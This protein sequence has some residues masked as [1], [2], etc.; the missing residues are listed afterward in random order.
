MTA[1]TQAGTAAT[2]ESRR[3]SLRSLLLDWRTTFGF[4]ALETIITGVYVVVVAIAI[5]FHEPWSDE[6]Q[7]WVI[8]RDNSVWQILRYRLHYEGS[9]A[10]WHLLVHCFQLLGGRYSLFDWFGACFAIGGVVVWLR[11]SPFP[12]PVRVLLPFTFFLQYQYAVIAR[13][14]TLFPL[15]AFT[16][17]VL[18]RSRRN[19]LWFAL[20][21]GLIANLTLQ[22]TVFSFFIVAL[23][24][25]DR[26][27]RTDAPDTAPVPRLLPAAA[28]Y[29]VLLAVAGLVALPAPDQGY[30]SGSQVAAGAM[31]DLLLKFPGPLPQDQ[32]LPAPPAWATRNAPPPMPSFPPEP[33]KPKPNFRSSPGRW[34]VWYINHDEYDAHGHIKPRHFTQPLLEFCI[35]ILTLATASI[36]SY[37]LL[38]C[39]FLLVLV[40]WLTVRGSLRMALPWIANVFVGEALWIADHHSGMLF[41]ALIAAAWLG[42]QTASRRPVPV[43]LDRFLIVL[44]ALVCAGQIAWS[45]V[46]IRHEIYE[47]YD[48]APETA[49][50][51][52][53]HPHARMAAF[54]FVA[55]GVQPYFKQNPFFN[56]PHPYWV[57]TTTQNANGAYASTIE[58]HPDIVLFSEDLLGPGF[59][60][61][62]WAPLSP[63]ASETEARD[64]KRNPIILDLE[65]H[66]YRQ[67]H[68]FCGFRFMRFSAS[69]ETCHLIYQPGPTPSADAESQKREDGGR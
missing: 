55:V 1:W 4:G 45:V 40:A 54:D 44:L 34:A 50:F 37:K 2:V 26:R 61:N 24:C 18:Y 6:A 47:P 63:L 27:Q 53:Q 31:H 67:T 66:G 21:A 56:L 32:H 9:P 30:A 60:R 16:L 57:W 35:D 69:Y 5:R 33:V 38:S 51:L 25:I 22:G 12:L 11:W 42:I 7:A 48:P 10:L 59:M 58:Q 19:P 14:Y 52:L 62:D 29:L 15:L 8:A 3:T 68:R 23:Y 46:S 20:V 13:G 64:L 36:A 43:L 65:A 39:G 17:C 49:S 41:I 28:L